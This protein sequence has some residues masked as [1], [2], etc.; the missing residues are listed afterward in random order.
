VAAEAGAAV[1]AARSCF[2]SMARLAV[3]MVLEAA[4]VVGEAGSR[5]RQSAARDEGSRQA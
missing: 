1:E 4:V 3:R 2:H 5:S